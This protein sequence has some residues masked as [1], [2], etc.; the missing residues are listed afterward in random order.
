MIYAKR[1]E[2]IMT[3]NKIISY[4]PMK[5]SLDAAASLSILWPCNCFTASIP[6]HGKNRLN[7]F[8]ETILGLTALSSG[9]TVALA[10]AS[11]L[12]ADLVSFIQ[13]RLVLNG[14]LD[15]RM[16]ITEAG[17]IVLAKV[18]EDEVKNYV[19]AHFFIDVIHGSMLPFVHIGTMEFKA[20]VENNGDRIKF[21]INLT[22]DNNRALSAQIIKGDYKNR[23]PNP[24][25][26]IR[27][28][29]AFQSR[30]R[31]YA[32]FTGNTDVYPPPIPSES[33]ITI[34][35]TP[36][37]MFL[38]CKAFIQKS[39]PDTV[40]VTDGFGFG[41]SDVF[42]DYL[43]TA[44]WTGLIHLQ[45]QARVQSS[46]LEEGGTGK[47]RGNRKVHRI[48]RLVN[49]ADAILGETMKLELSGE[50]VE[51]DTDE[52]LGNALYKIYDALERALAQV[53]FDFPAIN[54]EAIYAPHQSFEDNN[55]MLKSFANKLNLILTPRN[56]S[57]LKIKKGALRNLDSD[58]IEIQSALALVITG[59]AQSA[60]HPFNL[61]AQKHPDVLTIIGEIKELRDPIKHGKIKSRNL[62][63]NVQY[64]LGKIKALIVI[65]LPHIASQFES[66][67]ET[68]IH[69]NT[70]V[71]T[72]NQRRLKASIELDKYFGIAAMHRLNQDLKDLLIRISI[73]AESDNFNDDLIQSGVSNFASALQLMYH[74]VKSGI[75]VFHTEKESFTDI[76]AIAFGKAVG[77]GFVPG[78]QDIPP[79]LS[80][81]SPDKL[82]H[83]IQGGTYSLQ[84]DFI[85]L[86]CVCDNDV[87]KKIHDGY[88]NLL[89]LTAEIAELRGHGN[90]D[91]SIMTGAG[92]GNISKENFLELKDNVFKAIKILMEVL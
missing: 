66:H 18:E 28:I 36:D 54:W 41:Y 76:K 1:K 69:Y 60:D 39:N 63:R 25:D 65:L 12:K 30:F 32:D 38:H 24:Q 23:R 57:I 80:N 59:A 70:D 71:E 13:N 3:I 21:K 15:N 19:S 11:C 20:I 8:E 61:L 29:R 43:N 91:F 72:I 75:N 85:V 46:G 53:V 58:N 4:K 26:L 35:D 17:K 79:V 45:E 83:I 47:Q 48:A 27:T 49:E 52:K 6:H 2:N 73:N 55:E 64:Y 67:I 90:K 56:K 42:A 16:E 37:P 50:A 51:K 89:K 78:V 31:R 81:I 82:K 22:D 77:N 44:N 92:I 9:D 68:D 7:V 5:S 86:L 33:A 62:M 88:P 87:L 34:N 10:E 40:V 84:A 14:F 74:E